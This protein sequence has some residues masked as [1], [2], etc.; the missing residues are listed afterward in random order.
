MKC[1]AVRKPI[2]GEEVASIAWHNQTGVC[3]L[4]CASWRFCLLV[5]FSEHTEMSTN[6]CVNEYFPWLM[7]GEEI[8]IGSSSWMEHEHT[9]GGG[10]L[11]GLGDTN[12]IR[13]HSGSDSFFFFFFIPPPRQGYSEI[14]LSADGDTRE[15]SVVLTGFDW[16][17]EFIAWLKA[18]D[19]VSSMWKESV[20]FRFLMVLGFMEANKGQ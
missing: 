14:S 3:V 5:L 10:C 20:C 8:R 4:V 1:D 18:C 16:I 2:S 7:G 11:T 17:C 13:G 6:A 9:S 12:R 19:L 15:S